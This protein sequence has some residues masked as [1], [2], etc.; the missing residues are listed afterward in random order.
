MI[1]ESNLTRSVVRCTALIRGNNDSFTPS[2]RKIAL[3]VKTAACL[4]LFLYCENHAR[5]VE[6]FGYLNGKSALL[7]FRNGET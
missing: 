1:F 3:L 4:R 5:M 7:I 6:Y 2:K